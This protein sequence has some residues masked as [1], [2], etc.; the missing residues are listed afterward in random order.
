MNSRVKSHIWEERKAYSDSF[1]AKY[2][3]ELA[4]MENESELAALI[5]DAQATLLLCPHCG[6]KKI[7]IWYTFHPMI[8]KVLEHGVFAKCDECH[9]GTPTVH[10]DDNEADFKEALR[11]ICNTWNRRT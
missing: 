10:A 4:D 11:M 1:S 8:R 5:N 2:V 3:F 6:C 7:K 9:I